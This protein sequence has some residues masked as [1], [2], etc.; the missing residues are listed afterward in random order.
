MVGTATCQRDL[1]R[2][3]MDDRELLQ[4]TLETKRQ[5]LRVLEEQVAKFGPFVPV[6]LQLELDE[7]G[8]AVA[9]IES[10]LAQLEEGKRLPDVIPCP[11]PGMVP[12]QTKDARF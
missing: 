10:Q 5:V 3:A 1:E 9:D 6:Y 4:S 12:F 8:K 7:T 2:V 11:Y